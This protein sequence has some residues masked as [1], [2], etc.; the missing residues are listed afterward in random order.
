M[1]R[2]L[3]AWGKKENIW[4]SN[5]IKMIFRN[6]Y[7]SCNII[8]STQYNKNQFSLGFGRMEK[9]KTAHTAHSA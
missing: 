6:S 9:K 3:C 2:S 7:S 1:K 5:Q 8:S 4:K